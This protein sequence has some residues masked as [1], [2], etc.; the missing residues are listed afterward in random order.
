MS[1]RATITL[2]IAFAIGFAFIAQASVVAVWYD[3][4]Y[5]VTPTQTISSASGFSGTFHYPDAPGTSRPFGTHDG[6]S[7]DGTFGS[8]N[9]ASTANAASLRLNAPVW[10]DNND[11]G[12]DDSYHFFNITVK[13]ETGEDV[14]VESFNFDAWCQWGV[15]PGAFTD[16]S[17]KLFVDSG[18]DITAG[19]VSELNLGNHSGSNPATTGDDFD[20]FDFDLASLADNTLANGEEATF[21]LEFHN[22]PDGDGWRYG[23]SFVDNIAVTTN[24]P[25]PASLGLLALFASA[26]Y[27]I[28]RKRIS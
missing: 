25:E 3:G 6:G 12:L 10:A 18:S 1:K 5:S 14:D 2:V 15:S 4:A 22:R 9:G 27:F 21:R 26:M 20:D 11:S 19:E 8:T 7:T 23:N 17:F 13:N 16:N 28:R 24:I